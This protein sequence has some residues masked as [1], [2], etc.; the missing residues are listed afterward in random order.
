M[1][2]RHSIYLG[3]IALLVVANLW[4][5]WLPAA[6]EAGA[7]RSP[8]FL[9]QDFHLRAAPPVAG[10]APRRDLFRPVDGAAFLATPPRNGPATARPVRA[11]RAALPAP[12]AP[13]PAEPA[14][15]VDPEVAAADA[16]FGRLRLLGV[17]FHAGNKRA[18]LARNR[19]NIMA[20]IGLRKI[21]FV[22][23]VIML[24]GVTSGMIGGM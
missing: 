9:A 8:V 19:E 24:L 12:V 13:V 22:A 5:A 23:L 16:E 10:A 3:L 15:E 7:A 21:A 2:R 17:V 20:P 14:V 1:S 11:V 4:R 6:D 18:Y